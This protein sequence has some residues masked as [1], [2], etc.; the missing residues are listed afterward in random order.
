MSFLPV[1]K[2]FVIALSFVL[3]VVVAAIGLV[4]DV[5]V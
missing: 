2:R 1:S 4:A 5:R 3:C